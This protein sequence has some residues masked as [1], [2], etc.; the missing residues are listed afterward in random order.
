MKFFSKDF[1]FEIEI[2]RAPIYRINSGNFL[3]NGL[4]KDTI[5]MRKVITKPQL[6]DLE[7]RWSYKVDD[8]TEIHPAVKVDDHLLKVDD[9]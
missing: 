7:S 8:S 2:K 3:L 6:N 1:Y 4:I 5:A 9:P